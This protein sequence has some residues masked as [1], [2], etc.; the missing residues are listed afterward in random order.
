MCCECDG[1]VVFNLTG[2][3]DPEESLA[4]DAEQEGEPLRE[5]VREQVDNDGKLLRQ[6]LVTWFKF[7]QATG[8]DCQTVG[9]SH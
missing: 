4:E 1:I 7:R 8:K 9:C 6:I 3:P 5:Q 2:G